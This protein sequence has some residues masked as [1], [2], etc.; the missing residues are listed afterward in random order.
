MTRRLSSPVFVGRS[1]EL[2]ALLSTADAVASGDTWFALVGGE[3]GVGKSRLVAEAAS[4]LADRDWLVLEGGAVAV[5]DDGLPFGPVVEALR[6]LVRQV[7]GGR[8]ADAAGPNLPELARL[9]PELGVVGGNG[10]GTASSEPEPEWLQTR[11][12]SGILGLLGRLGEANPVLLVI[13]DLHWADR[14]TRDLL[15]FL[16][17]NRRDERLLV[18][19]TFRS[20]EL[21]RRHPLSAWLAETER[22]PRMERVNLGRFDRPQLAELLTAIVGAPVAAEVV[23][24]IASRSDGNAFFAE[25]LV[26][27][28]G[29]PGGWQT[30]MPDTLRGVLLVRLSAASDVGKRLVEVAAVAGRQVDHDVLAEVCGLSDDDLRNGLHELVDAQ[31]L[32]VATDAAAEGYRFR[33]ALVQEAAYDE[34]LPSERRVLH[35][36]Y[37]HA[38]EARSAGAGVAAASRLVELAHHWTAAGDPKRALDAAIEAGDAS[39]AVYAYADAARQYERA[40]DLWDFVEP[41]DRPLDR[42]LAQLYEAASAAA[43]LIGDAARAV[44]LGR[45][46]LELIDGAGGL[47]ADRERRAHARERLGAA[48]RLAA[49]AATTRIGAPWSGALAPGNMA[50]AIAA[51]FLAGELPAIHAAL[52]TAPASRLASA[53]NF[54]ATVATAGW[55]AAAICFAGAATVRFGTAD[56]IA[57]AVTVACGTGKGHENERSNNRQKISHLLNP[58]RWLTH[59]ARWGERAA[60]P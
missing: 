8:I 14:S 6:A 19:G 11:I 5:G 20:D 18:V 59:R 3:A 43:M 60:G 26:A 36:A 42:D 12:F 52:G 1:K 40:I 9:V 22:Q 28:D 35:A 49:F 25:E 54:A 23:E 56:E 38:I 29:A 57:Q 17:R 7:D 2:T 50:V 55:L 4:R 31:I 33:H 34:L 41:A 48:T 32:V 15:G 21:H 13:E 27:A 39:R 58:P 47:D 53:A 45:R 46:E 30:R 24:S 51:V 16:A 10:S 44:Q 37:A